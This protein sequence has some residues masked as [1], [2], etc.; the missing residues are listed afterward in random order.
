MTNEQ[1]T[2]LPFGTWPSPVTPGLVSQRIRLEDVQWAANGQALVWVEGRSSSSVL[3]AQPNNSA[4]RD[5]TDDQTPRG[6]VGYGGGAF[7]T[8]RT[9]EQNDLIVFANRDGR[10]FR[11]GLSPAPSQPITPALG[12]P[13]GGVASPVVSPDGRW[14]AYIYSDGHTDLIGLVDVD[15]QN[16]PLQ[17]ARGADFYMQPAWH[18]HG[19]RLAWVEWDQP[20]MPWDGTRIRLGRLEGTPPRLAAVKTVGGGPETPAQQPLF[21]PDGRWLSFVEEDGEWP[22]LVL[23]DLESG[24]RST[25]V[26]G[27]GFDL[28]A[29]A[30]AQGIRTT[31]W[32]ADSSR[33]YYLRYDGA[34]ASL[35]WVDVASGKVSKVDTTPYT[36]LSQLAIAPSGQEIAMIASAPNQPEAV[37]RWDGSRLHAVAHSAPATFDPACLPVPRDITWQGEDRAPVHGLYYPPTNP[38][39]AGQ[40]LPPAILSIHGGPTSISPNRFNAEAA[41]FTSRGFAYVTVNYRGSTG[42]GRAYRHAMRKRWGDVDVEDSASCARSLAALGLAD[43]NQ[44]AIMGGS[45]GGYTVLNT[46]IRYPGLFKAGICLYGVTRLYGLDTDTHKFEQHYNVTMVGALPEA[47]ERYRAWSPVFHAGRIRDALYI[48]QGS[49]DKVVPPNQ[50]E[51]IVAALHEKGIPYKYR[52][53]EGEGHGFRKNENVADFLKETERFLAEQLLY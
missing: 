10:L 45:A 3:V 52:L 32:S 8:G 33:L 36:W 9:G 12:Q 44:L 53:Y 41:Y 42:F 21:S 51:A 20:N 7:T 26:V 46:L 1:K 34:Q 49:E 28:A 2:I 16:W 19:D 11:R 40:G 18:P 43:P 39:Y 50:A 30:W 24:Q 35:W 37:V 6:G 25:L 22:N 29:P 47:A 5:L 4:R 27:Q 14:V 23:V 17:L 31:G 15:G 38:R 48:F 13:A